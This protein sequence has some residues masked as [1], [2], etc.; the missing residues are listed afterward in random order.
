MLSESCIVQKLHLTRNGTLG[1]F[2]PDDILGATIAI[3]YRHR[4]SEDDVKKLAE[5]YLHVKEQQR[6]H[7]FK[8]LQRRDSFTIGRL[9]AKIALK[10]HL[11]D[12]PPNDIFIGSGLFNQPIIL[13][14]SYRLCELGVSIS[15][16]DQLGVAIVHH[17]GHPIGIDVDQLAQTDVVPVLDA[18][19]ARLKEQFVKLSLSE[20][21][22][23]SLVWVAC[24]SLGKVLITGMMVPLSIYAPSSIVRCG[25]GFE[26]RYK[27][28]KQ[29]QTRVMP[30][31]DAWLAITFPGQTDMDLSWVVSGK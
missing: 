20:Y 15:H 23:A 17:K 7:K 8:Y 22:A 10:K 27:N 21:E 24:E 28:F 16:S 14:A 5:N 29:Y 25:A 18:M 4:I 2:S 26:L 9:A 13:G 1:T 30:F 12:V 11:D 6:R 19:D 31:A 3:L